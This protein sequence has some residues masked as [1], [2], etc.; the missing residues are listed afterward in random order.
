M[1]N[2]LVESLAVLKAQQMADAAVIACLLSVVAS[3]LP[4]SEVWK[5]SFSVSAAEEQLNA[6]RDRFA[7]LDD[8]KARMNFW[9][10][11]IRSIS[12]E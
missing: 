2:E 3:G 7:Q 1:N 5:Q 8:Y 10:G 4:L 12:P 9:D 11:L 6:L